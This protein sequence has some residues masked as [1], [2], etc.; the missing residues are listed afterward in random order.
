MEI[1]PYGIIYKITNKINNK[2]YIGL[3]TRSIKIRWKDH[4]NAANIS[5][6][7]K[8]YSNE[9]LY[10]AMRKYGISNFQIIKIDEAKNMDELKEKEVYWIKFYN[11]YV[12]DID[13]NGYNMTRGGD[14]VNITAKPV[15]QLSLQGEFIKKF[16]SIQEC[17]EETG[18]KHQ[19]ISACCRGISKS[20]KGSI[21]LFEE[22]YNSEANYSY[23]NFSNMSK[24]KGVIQLDLFGN[25][26]TEYNSIAYVSKMT[27]ITKQNIQLCASGSGRLKKAGNYIWT[28]KDNYLKTN[29]IKYKHNRGGNNKRKIVQLDLNNN[30]INEFSSLIEGAKY[31]NKSYTNISHCIRGLSET[32]YGYKW[33]YYENYIKQQENSKVS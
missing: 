32:A 2:V 20:C 6:D 27:G 9:A 25:L 17:V 33:M 12:D 16:Q 13:S 8:S 14:N 30:Y 28:Y 18:G 23:N 4:K 29:D 19:N 3:T 15:I 5:V 10:C 1:K 31:L 26:I 21:W 11:S 24:K 7:K 22:N